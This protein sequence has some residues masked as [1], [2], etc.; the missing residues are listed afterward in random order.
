MKSDVRRNKRV[1]YV[2][3]TERYSQ[4]EKS[5]M[6]NL[7]RKYEKLRRFIEA[8]GKNG[9]VIAFSGGVDS[10]TLATVSYD[11]LGKRAV[12]V[13]A[14]SP[15]YPSEEMDDAK[16]VAEEIGIKHYIVETDELS[17]VEFARNP[18]NR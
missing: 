1:A 5:L 8:K 4:K 17:N 7:D 11:V 18:E 15:T 2:K 13:T 16:R 6:K 14:K 9:V 10:S 12:A 3:M